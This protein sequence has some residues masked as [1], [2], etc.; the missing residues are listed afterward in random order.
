[1]SRNT[2]PKKMLKK[3]LTELLGDFDESK[4]EKF[5][6]IFDVAV[7]KKAAALVKEQINEAIEERF[8]GMIQERIEQAV[9]KRLKAELKKR[10]RKMLF[11]TLVLG[12]VCVCGCMALTSM[13]TASKK[14]K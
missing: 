9:K 14:S 5:K 7:D 1:M 6:E 11:R 3:K 13:E 4:K 10:T 8:D 2:V 12:A